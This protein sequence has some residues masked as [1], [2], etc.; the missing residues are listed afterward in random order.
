MNVRVGCEVP[1]CCDWQAGEEE[2]E[3]ATFPLNYLT[4]QD[5]IRDS[6]GV[7]TGGK[8]TQKKTT[9]RRPKS[10]A[11]MPLQPHRAG[12]RFQQLK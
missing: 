10:A 5:R 9:K 12:N 1:S 7:G 8:G 4:A 6:G 2:K 11:F 3:N